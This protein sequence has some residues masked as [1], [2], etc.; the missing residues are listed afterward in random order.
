MARQQYGWNTYVSHPAE[1]GRRLR[2]SPIAWRLVIEC[3]V[4][5]TIPSAIAIAIA[6][7]TASAAHSLAAPDL[8]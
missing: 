2:A 4:W 5:E 8:G 3:H 7:V 1:L 6:L